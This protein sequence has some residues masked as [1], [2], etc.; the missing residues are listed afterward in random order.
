M[1]CSDGFRVGFSLF[2]FRLIK[3]FG[4]EKQFFNSKAQ[5]SALLIALLNIPTF[6]LSRKSDGIASPKPPRS[7]GKKILDLAIFFPE[8]IK[9]IIRSSNA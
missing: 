9:E 1:R 5:V 2:K 7:I 8:L 3:S 6:K 4:M